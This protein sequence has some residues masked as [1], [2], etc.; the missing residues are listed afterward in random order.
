MLRNLPLGETDDVVGKEY[1]DGQLA[2]LRA[3]IVGLHAEQR[4][5]L[6]RELNRGLL[7]IATVVVAAAALV[8]LIVVLAM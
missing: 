4:E 1:F 5:E 7:W 6:R 3:E 8:A 2:G